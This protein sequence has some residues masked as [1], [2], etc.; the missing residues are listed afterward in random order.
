MKA[1]IVAVYQAQYKTR[2]IW[3][4]I[5]AV[6]YHAMIA[7]IP[8]DHVKLNELQLKALLAYL[9][10]SFTQ[11]YIESQARITGMGVAALEVKHA[12]N[13]P[14]LDVNKLN[15]ETLRELADLFDKLDSESRRIGGAHTRENV[16]RLWD[17]VISEIDRKI[18]E[19]VGVSSVV[20]EAAKALAQIMMERR[21][22][23]TEEARP[24]ALRGS[25]RQISPYKR[26][27]R[28]RVEESS[29]GTRLT[30]FL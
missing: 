8:K 16:K 14:I 2:F 5:N 20:G 11:L 21:L 27:R 12:E 10:S 19:I 29:G 13:L 17:T 30:D 4:R 25:E 22:S 3:N 1:P 6:T 15:E 24:E 7:F 28:S 23:R 26:R 9:N 18:S